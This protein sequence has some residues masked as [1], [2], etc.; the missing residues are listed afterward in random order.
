M[1]RYLHNLTALA[2]HDGASAC[3]HLREDISEHGFAVFETDG[4]PSPL[5]TTLRRQLDMFFARSA[6]EKLQFERPDIG[7]QRGYTPPRTERAQGQPPEA[8]DLKEFWQQGPRNFDELKLLPDVD[9]PWPGF[10]SAR[11]RMHTALGKRVDL[12]LTVIAPLLGVQPAW[13]IRYAAG[14]DDIVRYLRYFE[15]EHGGPPMTAIRSAPHTDINLVTLLKSLGQGLVVRSRSGAEIE[16]D[17]GPDQLVVQMGDFMEI[18][19][20][21]LLPATTH[22]VKNMP[23]VRTSIAYFDHPAP[24]RLIAPL[25]HLLGPDYI[26]D[27]GTERCCTWRRL[28]EIGIFEGPSPYE[29]ECVSRGYTFPPS[30]PEQI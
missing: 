28:I 29:N 1:S 30:W 22:W 5:K 17:I 3:N 8:A 26:C 11:R 27:P 19:S 10:D 15:L 7:H 9:T 21:G 2:N 20:G 18:L 13:L 23:G 16:L 4:I 6:S 12:V 14:G 24:L 25:P